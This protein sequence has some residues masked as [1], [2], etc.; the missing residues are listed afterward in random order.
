MLCSM[1]Q[2]MGV[3]GLSLPEQIS[4]RAGVPV[5]QVKMILAS[6][7]SALEL[8]KK[9][10]PDP[11]TVDF[12]SKSTGYDQGVIVSVLDEFSGIATRAS[13]QAKTGASVLDKIKGVTTP[14]IILAALGLGLYG[15]GM[16][17]PFIPKGSK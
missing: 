1:D 16:I 8:K 2:N 5:S 13:E 7:K 9:K 11:L 3:L 12:I 4:K 10:Y 6:Y 17:K 14:I 15:F